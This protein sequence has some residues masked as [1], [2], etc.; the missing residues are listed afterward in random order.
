MISVYI[1]FFSG[2]LV[3]SGIFLLKD[4]ACLTLLYIMIFGDRGVSYIFMDLFLTSLFLFH[5]LLLLLKI[6]RYVTW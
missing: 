2:T 4:Q 6:C 5:L 1:I 3:M